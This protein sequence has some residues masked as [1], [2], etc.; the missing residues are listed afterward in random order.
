MSG[1]D[2]KNKTKKSRP[3]VGYTEEDRI[4]NDLSDLEDMVRNIATKVNSAA[5]LNGGFNDL[6]DEIR[7][8]RLTQKVIE[9]TMPELKSDVLAIRNS[10]Y[11]PK[12][13][14]YAKLREST[15]EGI[16]VEAAIQEVDRKI[17]LIETKLNPIESTNKILTKSA[18]E[19]LEELTG[20]IQT[21]KTLDRIQWILFTALA[22]GAAK[23]VWDLL[24]AHL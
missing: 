23:F 17:N 18:G 6:Q 20:I 12:E 1:F 21:R 7:Q 2:D 22:G 10:I 3:P 16:K 15:V 13:G 4:R 5:V 19:N 8:I 14:I 11:D 9:T 24:E